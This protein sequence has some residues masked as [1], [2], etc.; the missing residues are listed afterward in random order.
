MKNSIKILLFCMVLILFVAPSC[1]KD[2]S[3]LVK[4]GGPFKIN[5]LAGN[6][7]AT[8]AF[9][10]NDSASKYI[11]EDGGSLSLSVESN[12]RCTLIVGP[13]DREAYTESGEMFWELYEGDY[14]FAIRWDAYPDDWATYGATYNDSTFF[15]NGGFDSGEYDFDNDGTS[16]SAGIG[17]AFKRI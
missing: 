4:E 14:Y 7:E 9:F 10:G 6:W 3:E 13:D 16:E 12:G 1:N 8:S 15:M 5:E 11:I 17:F 2:D